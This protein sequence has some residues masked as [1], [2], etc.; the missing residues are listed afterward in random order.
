MEYPL[1]KR[2]GSSLS[3]TSLKVFVTSLGRSLPSMASATGQ[4][5]VGHPRRTGAYLVFH[6]FH[7]TQKGQSFQTTLLRLVVLWDAGLVPTI[8]TE[9]VPQLL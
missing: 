2:G 1:F 8:G 9:L 4:R 6:Q 3:G 5:R 7:K